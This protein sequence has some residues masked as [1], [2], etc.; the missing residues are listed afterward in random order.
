MSVGAL[1]I[2]DEILT[3]KR[4]DRHLAHVSETLGKRGVDLDYAHYA[5]D[6]RGRLTSF[7]RESFARSDLLFSFGGIGATPDDHTR[8][9]SA[10][11]LGV[12]LVR[13][14][15]AVAEIEARFGAEAYPH[16]VLMAEFPAG[17][18]IIP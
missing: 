15:E 9:A 17:S 3:G 12:P 2:G 7:L 4:A 6:D 5:G 18:R 13:H 8:Q 14:P 16:R 10:A 1:I 11:A